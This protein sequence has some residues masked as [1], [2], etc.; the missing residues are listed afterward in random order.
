MNIEKLVY[1]LCDTKECDGK[2]YIVKDKIR[3]CKC[4]DKLLKYNKYY[5]AGINPEFWTFTEND[6]EESFS[7][8]I[9]NKYIF[10]KNNVHL[11]LHNK[12]EFWFQGNVGTG[13]SLIANLM[14][15]DALDKGYKGKT[16]TGFEV[17]DYLY[18]DRK[19]ELDE[20]D[21]L[22]I[23]EFDKVKKAT[24]QDFCNLISAYFSKKSIILLSNLN[25]VQLDNQ[26]YPVFFI[27]RLHL[28][29][30]IIFKS[31]SY[32]GKFETKFESLMKG[33]K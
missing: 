11:C 16:I 10:F 15:K 18:H 31:E 25:E 9:L 6:I 28:L 32:R 20:C 29:T 26:G 8:E 24:I 2:F 4:F 21:F 30:K 33:E 27:D 5:Q 7:K 17:I 12:V 22:V 1:D 3:E 13:K 23:D 19:K 14:L